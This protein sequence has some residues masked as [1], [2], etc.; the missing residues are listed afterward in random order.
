[1]RVATTLPNNKDF[2]NYT[3]SKSY[4]DRL[5][6]PLPPVELPFKVDLTRRA[7]VKSAV[8]EYLPASL[9]SDLPCTKFRT[10]MVYGSRYRPVVVEQKPLKLR[11]FSDWKM[12]DY[13]AI[14]IRSRA[15][16]YDSFRYSVSVPSQNSVDYGNPF[17]CR[18]C[19]EDT[20]YVMYCRP[21]ELGPVRK[22]YDNGNTVDANPNRQEL[23][24][25]RDTAVP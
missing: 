9:G 13:A 16:D 6:E 24:Y 4:S 20:R 23:D 8:T 15:I 12:P 18:I 10:G 5:A 7:S 17:I 2:F 19:G 1:M 3:P 25:G 22:S 11:D 14:A 21:R